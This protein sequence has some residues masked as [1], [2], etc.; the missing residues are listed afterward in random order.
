MTQ[1]TQRW[2]FVTTWRN[3]V[4]R[5]VGEGFIIQRFCFYEFAYLEKLVCNPPP[6]KSYFTSL[7]FNFTMHKMSCCEVYMKH[8]QNPITVIYYFVGCPTSELDPYLGEFP[9]L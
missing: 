9:N 2:C 1:G 7:S 6:Q 4:G 8:L 5:E 3:G